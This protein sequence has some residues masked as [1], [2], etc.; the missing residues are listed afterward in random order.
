[1]RL[2]KVE[3]NGKLLVNI[4]NFD[5]YFLDIKTFEIFSFLRGKKHLIL[6]LKNRAQKTYQLYRNGI[7]HEVTFWSIMRDNFK[8]IEAKFL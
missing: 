4:E 1:M 8:K 6:P 7:A 2:V 3:E 5:N